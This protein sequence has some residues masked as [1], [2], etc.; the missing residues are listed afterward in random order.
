MDL[1]VQ[2][3]LPELAEALRKHVPAGA[4]VVN[5]VWSD[6]PYLSFAAPEYEYAWALDPMFSYAYDPEKT[7]ELG[8]FGRDG[9]RRRPG[10]LAALMDADYAVVVF[11]TNVVGR[12]LERSGWRP[13]YRG[14]D[15][16]LFRLR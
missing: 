10:K 8:R 13:L 12:F 15:G 5:I 4:K 14:K 9:R 3:V 7:E 2:S 16:W 11:D 1:P 6:F